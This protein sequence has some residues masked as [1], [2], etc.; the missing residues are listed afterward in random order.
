M[1]FR[2]S[3]MGAYRVLWGLGFRLHASS[4]WLMGG[5][6]LKHMQ[7]PSIGRLSDGFWMLWVW[8]I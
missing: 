5:A 2:V 7:D 8:N 4:W 3:F 1:L 6:P